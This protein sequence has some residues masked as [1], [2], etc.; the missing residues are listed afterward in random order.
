MVVAARHDKLVCFQILV[1]DHLP[2][3]GA[4]EPHIVRYFPLGQDAL[5]LR[6]DDV[7]NPVH[8]SFPQLAGSSV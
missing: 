6:A 5:N 7:V 1:V 8:G 3:L 4:F 2:A